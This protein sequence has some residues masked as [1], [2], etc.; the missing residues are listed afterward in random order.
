MLYA[1]QI[2][3]NYGAVHGFSTSCKQQ[4]LYLSSSLTISKL[5]QH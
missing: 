5:I 3:H 4:Q 2:S 1:T